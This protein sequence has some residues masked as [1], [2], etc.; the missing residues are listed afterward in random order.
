MN[1]YATERRLTWLYGLLALFLT[2]S[3]VCLAIPY[4][5]WRIT[6]DTC[7]SIALENNNCGCILFGVSTSQYFNG[8]HSSS[9]LYAIFAPLPIIVYAIIMALFHMYRVCINNVGMYEDEKSTTVE[10]IEGESIVATSRARISHHNDAVIY[11]W[12]PTSCIAA[13][14]FIYNLGHASFITAG[15]MRT[16]TQYRGYIAR[17]LRATGDHVSVIH[18][19]LSC[20]AIFDFMD[21]LQKDAPNSRRGDF[22]NTGVSLQLALVMSWCAVAL[23]LL[24]AI[25]TARRAYKERDVL[26]CCGN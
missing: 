9:C 4:N 20:Q 19:R 13:I 24:V 21:Y 18:F 15:F 12:I 2:V 1:Q 25:Y 22:I 23:W 7:P 14:F 26:T 16:C 5:H 6:L 11:C 3:V 8:G 10:E 17:E